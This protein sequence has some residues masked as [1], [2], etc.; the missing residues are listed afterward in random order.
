MYYKDFSPCLIS[1]SSLNALTSIDWKN[2]GL[3]LQSN[4]DEN[5]NA[6]LEWEN[7]PQGFHIEIVLHHY[8]KKYPSASGIDQV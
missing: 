2:Y 4:S 1:R 3:T 5:S 7:L 8:Q 6:L